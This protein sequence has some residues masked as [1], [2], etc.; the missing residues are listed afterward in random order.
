MVYDGHDG[1]WWLFLILN[2]TF[3]VLVLHSRL[4]SSFYI[5][6]SQRTVRDLYS[7]LF[8][9]LSLT[10]FLR[11]LIIIYL[12]TYDDFIFIQLILFCDTRFTRSICSL[13]IVITRWVIPIFFSPA[14]HSIVKFISH[15][16]F[17]LMYLKNV[18]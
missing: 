1:L 3:S 10:M 9:L 12:Y 6:T 11:N 14:L 15:L 13:T 16:F 18:Y 8:L 4:F 2:L 5:V 7:S 17:T